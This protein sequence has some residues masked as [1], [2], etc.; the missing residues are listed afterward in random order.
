MSFCFGQK[1]VSKKTGLPTIGTIVG[2][3]E[4]YFYEEHLESMKGLHN[5]KQWYLLY[6]NWP[7][8]YVY[9]VRFSSRQRNLTYEEW[10]RSLPAWA[11]PTRQTYEKLILEQ[12]GAT[13]PE[14][15]LEPFEE[16]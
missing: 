14:E 3:T 10:C 5:F 6:P 8:R 15:D 7:T 13:Y 9:T 11:N 1:V 4:G 12:V 2:I 16:D